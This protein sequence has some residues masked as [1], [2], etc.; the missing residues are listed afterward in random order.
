MNKRAKRAQQ[1]RGGSKASKGGLR[2]KA[3]FNRVRTVIKNLQMIQS[4]V[5]VAEAALQ[6]QNCELD[7]DVASVLQRSVSNRLQDEIEQLEVLAGIHTD[8]ES[9]GSEGE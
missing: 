5:I 1:S 6:R 3:F 2:A 8:D 4:A 7:R 9:Q